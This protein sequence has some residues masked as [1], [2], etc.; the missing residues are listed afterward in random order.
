M[1]L[2]WLARMWNIMYL[3]DVTDWNWSAECMRAFACLAHSDRGE[4]TAFWWPDVVTIRRRQWPSATCLV[5]YMHVL[6]V[7]WQANANTHRGRRG[8]ARQVVN[9]SREHHIRTSGQGDD[10]HSWRMLMVLMICWQIHQ[11]H[12][13][14]FRLICEFRRLAVKRARSTPFRKTRRPSRARSP[15]LKEMY[16]YV[17]M[18]VNFLKTKAIVDKTSTVNVLCVCLCVCVFA[19]YR[20]KY[21]CFRLSAAHRQWNCEHFLDASPIRIGCSMGRALTTQPCITPRTQT[22]WSG[23]VTL[24]PSPPLGPLACAAKTN[25]HSCWKTIQSTSFELTRLL[26]ALVDGVR[27]EK[28]L[29]RRETKPHRFTCHACLYLCLRLSAVCVMHWY[30]QSFIYFFLRNFVSPREWMLFLS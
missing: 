19:N 25:T 3:M 1:E 22:A 15:Q 17:S 5:Q 8:Q 11:A 7:I 26:I 24:P 4:S 2:V 16:W 27:N 13:A 9:H 30:I 29:F 23:D 20:W 6:L 10:F 21:L 14:I 18:N 12:K 28:R